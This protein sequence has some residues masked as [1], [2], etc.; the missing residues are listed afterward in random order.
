MMKAWWLILSMLS[1]PAFAGEPIRF[2]YTNP[3]TLAASDAGA[4]AAAWFE[5]CAQGGQFADIARHYGPDPRLSQAQRESAE[6]SF[7]R[8]AFE[9]TAQTAFD[10]VVEILPQGPLTLCVD[11]TSPDDS[12]ARDRMQGV[13]AVTAGSGRIIVKLH[14]DAPWQ[15]LLPY[16]LAHELHHSYWALKHFDADRPFTLA[17]YLVF[18]GRADNFAMHVFGEHPAPWIN[19]LDDTQYTRTLASFRPLLGDASPQVLMGAMF[20]NPQAGIPLW[21]GYSVGYRLVAARI[22]GATP[23]WP[24][25]TAMPAAEF[26]P[27]P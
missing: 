21:A 16:V 6:R 10:R 9:R 24:A 12:F 18:E 11:F 26:I 1:G 8:E 2:H 27:A 4:A 23:D 15:R 20:G 25:I 19:A 13:M 7:D 17:D 22:E 3:A 5:Q 14:P